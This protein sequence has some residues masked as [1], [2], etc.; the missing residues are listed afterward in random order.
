MHGSLQTTM[1]NLLSCLSSVSVITKQICQ[2]LYETS[3][4]CFSGDFKIS[5]RKKFSDALWINM[6]AIICNN[7]KSSDIVFINSMRTKSFY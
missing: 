1:Y 3:S 5:N 6:T 7:I 2:D 4:V